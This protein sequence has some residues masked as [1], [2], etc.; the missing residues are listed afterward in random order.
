MKMQFLSTRNSTFMYSIFSTIF[1]QCIKHQ[2]TIKTAREIVARGVKVEKAA[3]SSQ[4]L[5]QNCKT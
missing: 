1:R 4:E 2:L 3:S 5:A